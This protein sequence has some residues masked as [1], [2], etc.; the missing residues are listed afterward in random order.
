VDVTLLWTVLTHAVLV[1]LGYA[2]LDDAS[3]AKTFFAPARVPA[4]QFCIWRFPEH[5]RW[6]PAIPG[7]PT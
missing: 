2:R 4:G 1:V 6:W 3:V 7:Y 5:N